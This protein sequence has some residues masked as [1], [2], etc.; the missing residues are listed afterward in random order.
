MM[1]T[2]HRPAAFLGALL[3]TGCAAVPHSID[4]R[5]S[6]ELESWSSA[7]GGIANGYDELWIVAAEHGAAEASG[8][9]LASVGDDVRATLLALD[10][11][12][13][14]LGRV[15]RIR[16]RQ[17]FAP[18]ASPPI[19]LEY[20]IA[21]PVDAAVTDF[22]VRIGERRIR[23]VVRERDE[24]A[25][26]YASARRQGLLAT[27]LTRDASGAFRQRLSAGAIGA[28]RDGLAIDL[29]YL[30]GVRFDGETCSLPLPATRQPGASTT[31]CIEIEAGVELTEPRCVGFGAAITAR[32]TTTSAVLT[33]QNSGGGGSGLDAPIAR[34][35]VADDRPSVAVFVHRD[36]VTREAYF[37]L[38]TVAASD[39]TI[40]W[41]TSAP[42]EV[43]VAG[44]SPA[45]RV[46]CGRLRGDA[47]AI[48]LRS[49]DGG[50]VVAASI[51]ETP[52]IAVRLAWA[53]TSLAER[54][55]RMEDCD[56]AP[57]LE[58]LGAEARDFAL[59]HGLVSFLTSFVLVD[60]RS[61]ASEFRE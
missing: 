54:Y 27:L 18:I 30:Q 33:L 14:V 42:V 10:I 23:G 31:A 22:V 25:R 51:V 6:G 35:R 61:N 4:P 16:L 56:D 44:T 11:D 34:W 52:D 12:A 21:L 40:D 32:P 46:L 39:L 9:E 53:A 19:G 36:P 45:Q 29:E 58:R 50:S 60:A 24:A 20:T 5:P 38:S 15:A 49:D 59:S 1:R 28:A 41:G 8:P 48:R 26:M 37:L 2:I 55:R 43:V 57:E 3:L 47:R 7:E 17:S 13:R